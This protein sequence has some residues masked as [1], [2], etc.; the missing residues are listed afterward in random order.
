MAGNVKE[1]TW[2]ESSGGQRFVLGG[3]WFEARHQFRDEDARLPFERDPGFGFRCIKPPAPIDNAL[4]TPIAPLA[5]DVNE[6]KPVGDEVFDG[7]RRLYDYDQRPLDSRVD[8]RDESNPHWTLERVSVTAAYGDER[9]PL[10]VF[11]PQCEQAAVSGGDL[12]SRL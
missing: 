2:N 8:E 9:L 6:L 4:L 1:W 11:I 7:Y 5:R 10:L 12:L 3:A